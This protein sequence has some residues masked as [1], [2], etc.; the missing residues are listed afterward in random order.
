MRL[1][2]MEI[3]NKEFKKGM[4]GYNTDEVDEFL[5][6]VVEDYETVFKENSSMKEKIENLNEKLNHYAKIETTIQN[7]LVLAQN[8]SDQ[9]RATAQKESDI[10]IKNANENA[11]R[12]I[13]KA[14]QEVININQ[15]YERLKQE[16]VKFR[17]KF[18]NFMNTQVETFGEMEKDFIKSY[19]VGNEI[20]TEE[21]KNK[22]ILLEDNLSSNIEDQGAITMQDMKEIKNFFAK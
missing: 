21:I 2:P 7:T 8:A 12:I 18:K 14:N 11:K 22:E 6:Q 4:R 20:I 13:D 15:D 17:A 9:A 19:S 1:T 10:I 5:D 16:F 3:N